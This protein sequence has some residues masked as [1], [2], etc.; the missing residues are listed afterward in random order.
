MEAWAPRFYKPGG[1]TLGRAQERPSSNLYTQFPQLF[2]QDRLWERFGWRW[3]VSASSGKAS[4][5][6]SLLQSV[7]GRAGARCSWPSLCLTLQHRG[8]LLIKYFSN[9]DLSVWGDNL[10]LHHSNACPYT[11]LKLA[12]LETLPMGS[13]FFFSWEAL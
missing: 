2:L 6:S 8:Q 11:E 1:N 13:S 5:N 12:S 10:F 4:A 3:P 9:K 7:H